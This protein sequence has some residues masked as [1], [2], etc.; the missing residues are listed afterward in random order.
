MT[1]IEDLTNTSTNIL[2]WV[3]AGTPLA[4][5]VISVSDV[6]LALRITSLCV[7]LLVGVS[8]FVLIRKKYKLLDKN[9]KA[10]KDID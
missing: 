10:S 2:T 6:E 9:E 7:G 5:T 3:G 8:S 1:R 4:A